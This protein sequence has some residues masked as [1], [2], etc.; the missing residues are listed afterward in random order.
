VQDVLQVATSALLAQIASQAWKPS[1]QVKPHWVPSQV[2]VPL[3]GT[4]HSVQDATPQELVAVLETQLPAQSCVPRGQTPSH[5]VLSG[6]QDGP[7]SFCPSGQMAPQLVP[8]QVAIPP[9]GTGQGVQ[10]VPQL[11]SAVL[12]TQSS[13]H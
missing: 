3:S 11:L 7:H 4:G 8:S 1:V 5:G 6:T 9:S 2:A 12:E 10:D 13:P